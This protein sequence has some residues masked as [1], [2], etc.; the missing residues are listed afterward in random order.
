[1]SQFKQGNVCGVVFAFLLAIFLPLLGSIFLPH[2]EISLVEKKKLAAFPEMPDSFIAMGQY[3][4]KLEY[5]YND[6][7][8]FREKLIFL[9][10]RLK[11]ALGDSAN[12]K[13]VLGKNGWL[14]LNGT[15]WDYRN[16]FPLQ[17]D[18]LEQWALT[19][20]AI[21]DILETKEIGYIFVIAPNKTTIYGENMPDWMTKVGTESI[22]DKFVSYMDANTA[23]NILDLRKSLFEGKEKFRL[24]NKTDSH[25]NSYGANIAQFALATSVA[26]ILGEKVIPK[27]WEG[28]KFHVRRGDGM[29]L[30]N[31]MGLKTLLNE[32]RPFINWK[33]CAHV[34][35]GNESRNAKG[36]YTTEC[37]DS[38]ARAIVFKD[39]FFNEMRPFFS[40]YFG[41][42]TYIN[43]DF[44]M[45]ELL[46]F[47][48]EEEPDIIIH[49]VAERGLRG[50]PN[51]IR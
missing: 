14:F 26:G 1:M 22:H 47:V 50:L 29:D 15:V 41:R 40:E 12:Q 42:V 45:D 20:Q 18:E 35:A 48:K 21:H 11:F 23:V 24:Y 10:N 6:N 39:S 44:S 51:V 3:A 34:L 4:K 28:S 46:K 37:P 5:Y 19:L 43:N 38:D 33:K 8:G 2:K 17:A 16:A 27:L 7:F 49:E 36:I 30:A 25:W 13:V 32:D 9:H 31:M